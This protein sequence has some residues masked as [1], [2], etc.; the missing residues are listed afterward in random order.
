MQNKY[1]I[2]DDVKRTVISIVRGQQ[3]RR[4]EYKAA[5]DNIINSGS[6]S[7]ETYT[8]A[9]EHGKEQQ[10]RAFMPHSQSTESVTERKAFALMEL[11]SRQSTKTMNIVDEA[12]G[13]I[14]EDIL[15]ETLRRDLSNAIYLNCLSRKYPYEHFCLP[16][17]SRRMFFKSKNKFL[18]EL[19]K[20]LEFF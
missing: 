20:K 15:N 13:S 9:D 19:A 8:Y 6:A 2:P 14:G 7:Y 10:A 4:A 1:K 11:N 16:G 18:F 5:Y 12:L 17:I 3:R